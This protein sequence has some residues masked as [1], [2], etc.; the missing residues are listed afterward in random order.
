[1]P[2]R[3]AA[4]VLLSDD[5][6]WWWDG[7]RWHPATA[8]TAGPPPRAPGSPW[9]WVVAAVLFL[10]LVTAVPIGFLW[11]RTG[12]GPG[13]ARG[14][15]QGFA[16]TYLQ[17]R[18]AALAQLRAKLA[19]LDGCEHAAAGPCYAPADDLSAAA[20]SEQGA[21]RTESDLFFF[22]GCLRDSA[23]VEVQAL[24]QVHDSAEGVRTLS[25]SEP[26]AV[27]IELRSISD[28]LDSA[29]AA[30]QAVRC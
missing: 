30:L 9:P 10:L 12:G 19:T 7:S 23:G 21:V 2:H 5:D 4:G 27:Q 17:Q 11:V 1:M 13:F 16:G 15:T 3:N 29:G 26:A 14:Y 6:K 28:A 25:S 22:P 24:Q 8:A 18:E 20:D